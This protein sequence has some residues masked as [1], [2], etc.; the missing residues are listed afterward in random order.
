MKT[1]FVCFLGLL[2]ILLPPFI[3]AA[4]VK[5]A[6]VSDSVTAL[7]RQLG[8]SKNRDSSEIVAKLHMQ[9][10][11]AVPLIVGE[12]R[13]INPH[14]GVTSEDE[15]WHIV[16]CERA[17]RSITGQ[18]FSFTTKEPLPPDLAAFRSPEE[19]LGLAMEWM[20]RGQV[21]VAP[22]DVQVQVINAW[23]DWLQKKGAT[24]PIQ[25][26]EPYGEWFW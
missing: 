18:Y 7:V 16:W 19:P 2:T 14:I 1:W 6:A 23:K 20:S 15:W 24:F 9:G 12:L 26:Y 11:L 13:V 8:I 25:R 21:F 5:P 4:D 3:L 17:L 22:R 10:H